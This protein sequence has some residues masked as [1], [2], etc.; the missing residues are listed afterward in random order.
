[1]SPTISVKIHDGS[2]WVHLERT[3]QETALRRALNHLE[4]HQPAIA[5][6]IL[7]R[8]LHLTINRWDDLV[9]T[10]RDERA[11]QETDAPPDGITPDIMRS[12]LIEALDVTLQ[13]ERAHAPSEAKGALD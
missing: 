12:A 13:S 1:M 6:Q 10:L 5:R 2:I 7:A 8:G 11:P 3:H 4:R 9:L